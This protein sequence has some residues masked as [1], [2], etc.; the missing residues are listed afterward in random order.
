M[1]HMTRTAPAPGVLAAIGARFLA[2]WQRRRHRAHLR[3]TIASLHNLSDSTL[4]DIGLQRGDIATRVRE[5][6]PWE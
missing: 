6:M 4:A 2:W 3:A 5:R 1:T